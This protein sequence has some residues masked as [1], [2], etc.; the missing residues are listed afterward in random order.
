MEGLCVLLSVKQMV[1]GIWL[2]WYLVFTCGAVCSRAWLVYIS[3]AFCQFQEPLSIV[4]LWE[5]FSEVKPDFKTTYMAYHYFR[6]KGWVPKVGLKYGTDLCEYLPKNG[7]ISCCLQ[8]FGVSG[9]AGMWVG[10]NIPQP[11]AEETAWKGWFA[12]WGSQ[13][14]QDSQLSVSRSKHISCSVHVTVSGIT[15]LHPGP[16]SVKVHAPHSSHF[17]EAALLSS[18]LRHFLCVGFFGGEGEGTFFY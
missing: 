3:A 17:I 6:G 18:L 7:S 5:V 9:E 8:L 4:K 12:S 13:F 15:G 10:R 1:F 14:L 11:V 16:N 2:L